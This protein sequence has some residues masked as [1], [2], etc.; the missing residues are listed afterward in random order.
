MEAALLTVRR[1]AV[2][3]RFTFLIKMLVAA[4]L[5]GLA[6]RL[7]YDADA[8]G[9]TLG[10][11]AAALLLSVLAV[12]SDIRRS[13]LALIAGLYCAAVMI[14]DP[15]PLALLLFWMS[16]NLAVLLPRASGF[17][18]G[19][20]WA[21]R[22]ALHT[23]VTPA[24]PFVDL[25]RL[26][27][28]RPHSSGGLRMSERLPMLA[29]PLVGSL[30]FLA[31]FAQANPL[32]GDV[33]GNFD[34]F[35][36]V[37]SISFGRI[38]FWLLMLTIVWRVLRPKMRVGSE[39]GEGVELVLPGVNLA[40]VALS[41]LA[42][43]LIFAVQNLLD[44]AFLWSGGALPEG[45]SHA[46]YAHRG[47][48]PL[49]ATALLAGLF[50]L[51]TLQP[52]SETATSPAVRRLVYVWIAQN[53]FLVAST[54]LRTIDYIEAYSLTE[55]R[56][57]AL[58]WMALVAVGL[59]LICIRIWRRKSG[60]WLLNA[61]FAA[62]ASVLLVSAAVDYDRIAA[63]WN[64]R[65]AREVGGEGASLDLC[66]LFQMGPSSL[67]PLVELESRPIPHWL[68]L[69]VSWLRNYQMDMLAARQ[70]GRGGWTWRGAR[71]LAAA[72][73]AVAERKLPRFAAPYR[74][75]DGTLPR[76]DIDTVSTMTPSSPPP[77]LTPVE[78]R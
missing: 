44:L 36:S 59:V 35:G 72:E 76:N 7:F 25:R 73:A 14:E 15:G 30:V 74:N 61:N 21:W 47:A 60:V 22:L 20:T 52:G 37:G 43:N 65:H 41:L 58:I 77:P 17:G 55:L 10:I 23:L 69:R 67:M 4:A 48:Y 34:P 49:I 12:R 78:A 3:A 18:S 27:R 50:V 42:F 31:L 11:F 29:L 56:I 57:Q 53:V 16:I 2:P 63:G 66:Y 5:I 64:V 46:Q 51:A 6:D 75:C 38:A 39:A 45:M 26:K 28:V 13:R 62:A 54:M 24:R 71:R 9:A 68:R 32:I 40:S 33:L 1:Q 70:D 8:V 19:W